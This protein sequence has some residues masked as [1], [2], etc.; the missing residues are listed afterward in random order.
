MGPDGRQRVGEGPPLVHPP[1]YPAIITEDDP[2]L[3]GYAGLPHPMAGQ[4]HPQAGQ[5]VL[6]Y[7]NLVA[8][9]DVDIE[10]DTQQ[11]TGNIASEQFS[12]L[13]QLVKLSPAYQQ[14]APLSMLIELSTI[15]HKRNILDQIKQAAA[16]QQAAQARQQAMA[17]QHAQAQIAKTTS[18]AQDH[19]ASGTARM[20]NALSEAHAVHADHAAA[21]FEAGQDQAQHEQ[22][23]ALTEMQMYQGQDQ[24][25]PPDGPPA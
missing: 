22:A 13:I 11:D 4:P 8:E 17:A 16:Q 5:A 24:P 3:G 23:Q 15:P 1:V 20:L 7:R 14:Q 6:G 2:Q 21:G 19:A 18:E 25:Q 12:E 9:M 10:V